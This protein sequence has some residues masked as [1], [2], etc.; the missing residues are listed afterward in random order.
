MKLILGVVALTIAGMLA[1]RAAA[2]DLVTS[3][4]VLNDPAGSLTVADAA[5]RNGTPVG[6]ILATGS[7]HSVLWMRVRVRPPAQ[8]TK[9]VLYIV[10]TFLNEIRLYEAGPGD[11]A[12]WETRVTGNRYPYRLRDRNSTSLGF[13]VNVTAPE[14]TYY[15][16]FNTRSPLVVSVEALTPE[17]ADHRDH[18]RDLLEVFFVTSMLFLLLWAIQNYLL[19]RQPVVGMFAIHQ[20]VYTLFGIVATGYLAPSLGVRF[21][22][23]VDLVDATLYLAINFTTVLFCRELFKPYRPPPA[24]M[25]GLTAML[26]AYP[27]L[28]AAMVLGFDTLAVNANAILIKLAWVFLVVISFSLRVECTPKRRT[29]QVFFT[30]VLLNN[31]IFWY[32]SRGSIPTSKADLGMV[33]ILI[34]DGLVIGGL[35]ALML[36]AR[37][38][39]ALRQGQLSALELL[40]VQKKF[41]KEQELK[42]HIEVQAWTDYLTGLSNRRHFVEL[43]DRELARAIRFQRPL[44]LLVIDFDHFKEINDTWGHRAG[45]LVLKEASQLLSKALRDEDIFGR[46]GGEEFA[47]VMVETEGLASL[48]VAQRLCK[49][50]ADASIVPQGCDHIRVNISIGLTEL[51]NRKI[52]FNSLLDEADQAM[53]TAKQAGR[54]QVCISEHVSHA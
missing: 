41:E 19:D 39:Q 48:E 43:A 44:S 18:R 32:V 4:T 29:L 47:I 46:I 9:V 53:Y 22:H 35:I 1:P 23:L 17:E 26:L 3:R 11:P 2:D 34:V 10:P 49:A 25:R 13:V 24:M 15:L 16:R 54:N 6:Q 36:N 14:A 20:A 12:T 45:D 31:G 40:Q 42:K 37:T 21:P 27:F 52:D 7:T 38:R 8:G 50:V 51:K 33:Q 30:F 28:L 5:R